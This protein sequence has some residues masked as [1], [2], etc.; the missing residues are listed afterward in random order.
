[1]SEPYDLLIIGAGPGGYTCAFR[2]A[3]LGLKVGLIEKN[4][5]L[6]GTCLNVGCIPSKALLH[7]SEL[8][9][10]VRT[11]GSALGV[12][13]DGLKPDIAAMMKHKG[14]VV[15]QL[16][17][18][19]VQLSKARKVDLF[20]GTG[21]LLA[22][23]K[24][25]VTGAETKTL[26]APHLVLATGSVPA[27]LPFLDFNGDTIVS[28]DEAIAFESA[29]KR[30]V[31]I[32]GGAIGLELGSVWARLGSEVTV[33]EFLPRIAAGYDEDITKM[34][35]RF[36]KRQGLKFSTGTKV[37]A[38]EESSDG[39]TLIGERK[40]KEVRFE[41]DKILVAV[42][43]KAFTGGLGLDAVGIETDNRGRIPVDEHLQTP[44]EGIYAIGDAIH[45]PM[46]AHKAEE[47]GIAVAERIAGQGGHV[48][49]ALVPNVIYTDPEIASV[50][51]TETLAK[52][53]GLAFHVGKFP[54]G[55][56]GRALATN[57]TNG[58]IKV[59]SEEETDKLL[60]VQ[61][62]SRHGSE[63][64]ANAAAHMSYGG[65]AEDLGRTIHAHPTLS[66]GLKEAALAANGMALSS[67]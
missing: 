40:G 13:G 30:L 41:A 62:I 49:Y 4:P 2:A 3:Q 26:E 11:H 53:K 27:T 33:V 55:A 10:E 31:V 67:L 15:E 58:F 9:H 29:P 8:L 48:D 25:E 18:G 6:G 51:L 66:E 44:V 35:E 32:G 46:L 43:R 7:A 39:L 38:I 21:K 36:F 50:G 57:A 23:G 24:V 16:R 1:M 60:G 61:I 19:L 45:G 63:L 14:K 64:I 52:E 5:H 47:D 59:I 20:E 22:P 28:S 37:T 54:L 12:A 65:S 56:N 34:A 17:K 42:G